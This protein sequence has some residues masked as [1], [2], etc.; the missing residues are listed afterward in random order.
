MTWYHGDCLVMT[1]TDCTFNLVIDK[2][3]LECVMCSSDQIDR[4][5]NKYRDDVGRVLR[6]GDLED[7]DRYSNNN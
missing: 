6:L 7:E 5:M 3:D 2:G 4:R 1:P